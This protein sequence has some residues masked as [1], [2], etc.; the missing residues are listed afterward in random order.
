MLS[1]SDVLA[2]TQECR[3]S[4]APYD[5]DLS[6]PNHT[7]QQVVSEFPGIRHFANTTE[8]CLD[9]R[10]GNTR[11]HCF[12]RENIQRAEHPKKRQ[13]HHICARIELLHVAFAYLPKARRYKDDLNPVAE[14]QSALAILQCPRFQIYLVA[15]ET[16]GQVLQLL[17][18]QQQQQLLLLLLLLL[19]PK[20]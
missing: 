15:P 5:K 18:L 17:L 19:P 13:D 3:C 9:V 16:F 6:H 14:G 12:R 1:H 10:K 8:H 4:L 7:A 2:R 11:F 20:L